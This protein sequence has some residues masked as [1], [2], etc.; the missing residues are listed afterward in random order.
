MTA[1]VVAKTLKEFNYDE[2]EPHDIAVLL[3]QVFMHYD[4]RSRDGG[5]IIVA[6]GVLKKYEDAVRKKAAPE[7]HEKISGRCGELRAAV[8]DLE[9]LLRKMEKDSGQART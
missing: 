1:S 5:P 8:G 9:G 2:A 4:G 7:L 6:Q 3:E